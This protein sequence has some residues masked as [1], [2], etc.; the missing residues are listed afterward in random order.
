[1]L[2][3]GKYI[4]GAIDGTGSR[5]WRKPDGSNSHT[6]LFEQDFITQGGYKDYWHGPGGREVD[7]YAGIDLGE[8]AG[9]GSAEIIQKVRGFIIK[10]IY[11]I[12]GLRLYKRFLS[13][14]KKKQRYLREVTED[15]VRICLVGHSRGAYLCILIAQ[16]LSLPVYYMA[17]YDAVDRHNTPDELNTEKIINVDHVSHA[18]RDPAANSRSGPFP[19]LDFSNTGL[20]IAK[21]KVMN[22]KFFYTTHGGVG[23]DVGIHPK[24][25][26]SDY[27][28]K[29]NV[30]TL[31]AN[32]E[33]YMGFS[34]EKK[35]TTGSKAADIWIREE[36][37][38]LGLK[39]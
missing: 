25:F 10:N 9:L 13:L 23:G 3:K 17:L 27:A 34:R 33:L 1:M 32:I 38:S 16:L 2:F 8:A 5:V 18:L 11:Q 20:Q 39:F 37:R 6:F 19:A 21:G 14:S 7:T 28:S 29:C 24:G 36:A 22:K 31:Q 26:V 12:T 30:D 15:E 4:L 35:C